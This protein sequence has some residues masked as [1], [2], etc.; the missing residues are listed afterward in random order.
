MYSADH[1]VDTA[2]IVET[3]KTKLVPRK[4]GDMYQLMDALLDIQRVTNLPDTMDQK[5]GEVY[6]TGQCVRWVV[7][8][9]G[10]SAAWSYGLNFMQVELK[11]TNYGED[12]QAQVSLIFHSLD[13]AGI[14]VR[15]PYESLEKALRR[16][17]K[18]RLELETMPIVPSMEELAI[19]PKLYGVSVETN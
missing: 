1:E 16:H 15:G 11:V 8:A 9:P 13:D 17:E 4:W 19:W 5:T 2:S 3:L 12:K 14:Y 10:V 18:L 6:R 7:H